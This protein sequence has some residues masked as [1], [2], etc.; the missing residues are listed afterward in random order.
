MKRIIYALSLLTVLA[1]I[2]PAHATETKLE[3]GVFKQGGFIYGK[4]HPEAELKLLE[5]EIKVGEDGRFFAGLHRYFP[6][7]AALKVSYPDGQTRTIPLEV[8]KR[9]YATQHI[10]GVKRK[11]VT[12]DP[13]QVARSRREAAAIR[14]SRAPF[15][16]LNA[17]FEGFSIPVQDVPVTGV[18]GSRR[19]FN[20]EERSWHKGVDY[21]APIGTPV[22]APADGVVTA[23]LPE[24]F[25]N[26][27]I[28][29]IDH[30]YGIFTIYAHLDAIKAEEGARVKEGDVI[31]TVGN[32]GRSTGPHLHWGVYWHNV[33]LDPK[34]FLRHNKTR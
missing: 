32:T 20:G 17:A 16:P 31:A 33:A 6:E 23:A 21:A 12:P 22:R 34:L 11:H 18:Y 9:E 26:G 14:A 7:N 27:N 3:G 10:K 4:T 28:M 1:G 30:G 24:T 5:T 29:T 25:F 13:E 2:S 8:E 15:S 19:T